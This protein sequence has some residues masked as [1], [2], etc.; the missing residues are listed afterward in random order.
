MCSVCVH[1]CVKQGKLAGISSILAPSKAM[2]PTVTTG[3]L[4]FSFCLSLSFSLSRHGSLS[5]SCKFLIVFLSLVSLPFMFLK[6]FLV[7]S[8]CLLSVASFFS[9]P[10]S[11]KHQRDLG[12]P[13]PTTTTICRT[14]H[15]IL[16]LSALGRKLRQAQI[17]SPSYAVCIK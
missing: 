15:I 4:P 5:N 2:W 11:G 3:S 7:V 1:V 12:N 8:S 10:L 14:H 6:P 9:F 16:V 13:C 17:Q